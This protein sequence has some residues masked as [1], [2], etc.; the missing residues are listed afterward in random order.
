ME[1][2]FFMSAGNGIFMWVTFKG[3]LPVPREGKQRHSKTIKMNR[4]FKDKCCA[5][6]LRMSDHKETFMEQEFL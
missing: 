2:I 1:T 6:S 3:S 4:C 5:E